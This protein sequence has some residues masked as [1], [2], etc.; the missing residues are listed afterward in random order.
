VPITISMSDRQARD[1]VKNLQTLPIK[2]KRELVR[3]V[4]MY[5]RNET[6]RKIAA[7]GGV[8]PSKWIRARKGVQK[9]FSGAADKVI[10][11]Q[12]PDGGSAVVETSDPR[13]TLAQH[14]RG[15]TK[16]AGS[17]GASDRVFGEWVVIPLKQPAE[18]TRLK[19]KVPNPFQFKW[20]KNR[21]PSVVPARDILP[22][23]GDMAKNGNIIAQRWAQRIISEAL[24][25]V[26]L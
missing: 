9:S 6:R 2:R 10:L 3:D 8:P 22:S 20:T 11:A 12:T 15:Y 13:Y 25:K 16:P 24:A 26:G 17:G 1:F 19:D 18:L 23:D 5:A 4:G 21:R 7:G 14:A